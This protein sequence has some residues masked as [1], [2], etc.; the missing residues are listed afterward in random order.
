M[1]EIDNW[2]RKCCMTCMKW[3]CETGETVR[4]AV[5]KTGKGYVYG[6]K[7]EVVF[8]PDVC[9][10]KRKKTDRDYRCDEYEANK[11]F[12]K[13]MRAEMGDEFRYYTEENSWG[14]VYQ[15]RLRLKP[16]DVWID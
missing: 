12:I 10:L 16:G 4:I 3:G 14:D 7:E 9:S 5:K 6:N 1:G 15:P 8:R 13:R 2:Y 11:D